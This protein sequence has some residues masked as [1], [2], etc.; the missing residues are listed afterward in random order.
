MTAPL[1]PFDPRTWSIPRTIYRIW[2]SDR[3]ELGVVVDKVDYEW[4]KR[5]LW[6]FVMDKHGK[7]VYARRSPSGRHVW[8]H[9]EICGRAHGEPTGHRHTI[10]DHING[11][12]M[13]CR[14]SN[15]RWTCP[16]GNATN[17]RKSKR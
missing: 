3:I 13:N 1:D 16:S 7:K 5:W 17:R 2:L 14:R 12:T 11:D 6:G 8:L 15:L 9:K 10:A 4:A